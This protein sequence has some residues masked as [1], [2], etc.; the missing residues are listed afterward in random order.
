MNHQPEMDTPSRLGSRKLHALAAARADWCLFDSAN[1]HL[2]TL[3][4]SGRCTVTGITTVLQ[5]AKKTLSWLS[6]CG[7]MLTSSCR[8]EF[9]PLFDHLSPKPGGRAPNYEFGGQ[10]F[11]SLRARHLRTKPRTWPWPD[12]RPAITAA[13]V[14]LSPMILTLWSSTSICEMTDCRNA[15]RAWVSPPSSF[16]RRS[17]EKEARRSGVIIARVS[18]WTVIRSRE[19]CARSRCA[20]RASTRSF[21]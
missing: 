17:R 1:P 20:F 6:V 2:A 21:S 8:Y 11:E 13:K 10:E 18:A 15:F 5:K 12:W 9:A 3:P 19:A 16:S 4:C 7:S 14:A